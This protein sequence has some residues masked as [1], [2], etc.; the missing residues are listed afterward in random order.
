MLIPN[1]LTK[2]PIMSYWFSEL[3]TSLDEALTLKYRA[4][5]A[6]QEPYS[7]TTFRGVRKSKD[8]ASGLGAERRNC[9][10]SLAYPGLYKGRV[11][12]VL[13]MFNEMKLLSAEFE[14]L[15]VFCGHIWKQLSCFLML[16]NSY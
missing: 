16:V 5:E 15:G 9:I 11:I 8:K 13:A 2:T 7:N 1:I 4:A 3:I 6:Y 12:G 10:H 14:M